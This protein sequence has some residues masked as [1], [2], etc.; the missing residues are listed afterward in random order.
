MTIRERILA[1]LSLDIS[2]IHT[3][4]GEE[5][6]FQIKRYLLDIEQAALRSVLSK[7]QAWLDEYELLT[8]ELRALLPSN[9]VTEK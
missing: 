7:E 4:E 2:I 8:A 3:L 5:L 1:K 6:S 9:T